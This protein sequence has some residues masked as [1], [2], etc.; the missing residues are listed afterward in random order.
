MILQRK[1]IPWALLGALLLLLV[2]ECGV[3]IAGPTSY[4][5]YER[6]PTA[7]HAVRRHVLAYGS[8]EVL[9]VGSSRSEMGIDCPELQ[10]GLLA[11]WNRQ[12]EVSNYALGG[13]QAAESVPMVKHILRHE[14]LPK[15]IIYGVG[16]EQIGPNDLIYDQYTEQLFRAP[17]PVNERA[18]MFWNMDDYFEAR[19]TFGPMVDEYLPIVTRNGIEQHYHTLR[20]RGR[21]MN[22][23]RNH[24]RGR[25]GSPILGE[26]LDLG[27]REISMAEEGFDADAI[28]R[29]VVDLHLV[30]GAYPFHPQRLALFDQ[31][32]ANCRQAGVMLVFVELPNSAVFEAPFPADTRARFQ[33]VFRNLA[34]QDGI[35]FYTLEDLDLHEAFDYEDFYDAAHLNVKGAK[36]YTQAIA[37]RLGQLTEIAD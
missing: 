3:R 10:Q 2:V 28:R 22:A 25:E 11:S 6:G 9:V 8:S 7:R 16:Q 24:L 21:I 17:T 27:D 36:R 13:A 31:L 34:Q 12:V 30:D 15:V 32:V 33:Q 18:A 5:A 26:S 4:I 23:L 29:H 14:P 1:S 20:V 19:R 35:E 37:A